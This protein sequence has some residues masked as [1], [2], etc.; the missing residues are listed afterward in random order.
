MDKDNIYDEIEEES[1][2]EPLYTDIKKK[3]ID[4]TTPEDSAHLKLLKEN[5]EKIKPI[6]IE[7]EEKKIQKEEKK[8]EKEEKK[9]EKDIEIDV[10]KG[11]KIKKLIELM[12]KKRFS[13]IKEI[14]TNIKEFKNYDK[15][16]ATIAIMSDL[17]DEKSSKLIKDKINALL[18]ISENNLEVFRNNEN[19]LTPEFLKET[20]NAI[21]K[22][23]NELDRTM[24]IINKKHTARMY[25]DGIKDMLKYAKINK[26]EIDAKLKENI[27]KI[28]NTPKSKDL[29][30]I[31]MNSTLESI[32]KTIYNKD[33]PKETIDHKQNIDNLKNLFS[34]IEGKYT[35]NTNEAIL[36]ILMKLFNV[37][38]NKKKNKK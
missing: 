5:V 30:I 21:I 16:L 6:K 38:S 37:F 23:K 1:K 24:N 15:Q 36:K 25:R 7:K 20:K 14:A 13:N 22:Q 17:Y 9:I 10:K 2:T 33:R 28:K 12:S 18:K 34:K 19:N 35:P 32:F 11:A 31:G 8:I 29:D 4:M 26:I 3:D 27:N